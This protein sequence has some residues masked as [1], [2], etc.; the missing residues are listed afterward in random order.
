MVACVSK[1]I[2]HIIQLSRRM[3]HGWFLFCYVAAAASSEIYY[4]GGSVDVQHTWPLAASMSRDVVIRMNGEE[5]VCNQA[6]SNFISCDNCQEVEFSFRSSPHDHLFQSAL[7]ET[8]SKEYLLVEKQQE[9]VDLFDIPP[10]PFSSLIDVIDLA[11]TSLEDHLVI[12]IDP[13]FYK[14][15]L[16]SLQCAP[17]AN[18]EI[19]Q[20][21]RIF[22]YPTRTVIINNTVKQS[23]TFKE[24]KKQ[25]DVDIR[26]HQKELDRVYTRMSSLYEP[27]RLHSEI[28]TFNMNILDPK[29]RNYIDGNMNELSEL[30]SP[31]TETGIYLL[32]VFTPDFCQ[33]LIEEVDNYESFLLSQD[34]DP[35]EHRPNFLNKFGVLLSEMGLKSFL[36]DF[37]HKVASKL[38]SEL[39]YEW[40]GS[41]LDSH[42]GFIVE[43]Q[44]G[45]KDE[46]LEYHIDQAEATLNVC[47]GKQFDGGS[48]FFRGIRNHW[49]T[50]SL[51][52][53][54]F[55]FQH[56][57]GTALLHIGQHWHG[58]NKIQTGERYN[59]I[60]WMRSSQYHQS[61]AEQFYSAQPAPDYFDTLLTTDSII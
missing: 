14:L 3:L 51:S 32:P 28:Y 41:E 58:A 19:T 13:G 47:L 9:E 60:L 5:T 56:I 39:F 23:K 4:F 46:D 33:K 34:I 11:D 18:E 25:K 21:T 8:H 43:Y 1:R 55:E 59:L 35:N 61:F 31:L 12:K 53:E 45:A 36:D 22:D 6:G 37:L 50:E 7:H 10:I 24:T 15:T 38:T 52:P 42:H 29:L 54:S 40:G 27:H 16:T 17:R 49:S 44:K 57:P 20:C 2:T 30:L 48:L 26:Q